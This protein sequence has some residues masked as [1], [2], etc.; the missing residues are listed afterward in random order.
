M[1]RKCRGR[2]YTSGSLFVR[3]RGAAVPNKC[4]ASDC[5]HHTTADM[6]TELNRICEHA[7]TGGPCLSEGENMSATYRYHDHKLEACGIV[8]PAANV[9]S[10]NL[11]AWVCYILMVVQRDTRTS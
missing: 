2:A 8:Y 5:I 11:G 10:E 1:H 3:S 7:L 4:M 9:N 6:H